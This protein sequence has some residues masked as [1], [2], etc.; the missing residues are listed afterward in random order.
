MSTMSK[1]QIKN[2]N[3]HLLSLSPEEARVRC[4]ADIVQALVDG[5]RKGS[6][7]DLNQV[8]T[9]WPW[10][11]SHSQLLHLTPSMHDEISAQDNDGI[12]V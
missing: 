2:D 12:K 7:V 3:M 8:S 4:I 5:V 9:T 6:D 11:P 1:N 10:L